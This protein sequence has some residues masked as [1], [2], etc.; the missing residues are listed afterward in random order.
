V[1]W[2]DRGSL[3]VIGPILS[4]PTALL[5]LTKAC[6]DVW[7]AQT[8]V[9]L[10]PPGPGVGKAA[11]VSG[12]PVGLMG[13]RRA[14]ARLGIILNQARD[15]SAPATPRLTHELVE[16]LEAQDEVYL[17]RLCAYLETTVDHLLAVAE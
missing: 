15:L 5:E 13:I 7:A 2:E 9:V 3:K 8:P 14:S 16:W 6:S 4:A 11:K 10:Q 1:V 17:A 12:Q